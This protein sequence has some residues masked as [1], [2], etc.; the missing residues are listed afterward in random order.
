ME[1][2]ARF[3][4]FGKALDAVL[5]LF[6]DDKRKQLICKSWMEILEF[7]CAESRT[8]LPVSLGE[9]G[10]SIVVLDSGDFDWGP[11][12]SL[13]VTTSRVKNLMDDLAHLKAFVLKGENGKVEDPFNK[14]KKV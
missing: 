12:D 14:L 1:Y 6:L 11:A 2:A 9:E 5:T 4:D 7:W 13:N 10:L 3:L 8:K